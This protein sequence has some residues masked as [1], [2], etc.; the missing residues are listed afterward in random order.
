M[1]VT[2]SVDLKGRAGAHKGMVIATYAVPTATEAVDQNA[3]IAD[4]DYQLVS[5]Q[6]AHSGVGGSGAAVRITKCT[7]TQAPAA[8]ANMLTGTLSL[9]STINTVV[10]GVLSATLANTRLAEG[11]RIC[12]DFSGTVAGLDGMA[13][14]LILI[15]DPDKRYWL[16]NA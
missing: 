16:S 4:Q 11:N 7:G 10:T 8:G 15:P 3:F 14:T 2:K 5:V 9:T 12:L 1:A 6:E 13:V